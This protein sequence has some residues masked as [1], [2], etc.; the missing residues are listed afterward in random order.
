[1]ITYCVIAHIYLLSR[2]KDKLTQV[3]YTLSSRN[4]QTLLSELFRFMSQLF[5]EPEDQLK[6]KT[7]RVINRCTSLI[8]SSYLIG[9]P[10]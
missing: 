6:N 7:E 10:P 2:L 8:K 4:A 1:M 3:D 5:A 9:R